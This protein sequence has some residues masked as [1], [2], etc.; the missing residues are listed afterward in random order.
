MAA[1]Q[2]PSVC[3]AGVSLVHVGAEA[4]AADGRILTGFSKEDFRVF[5]QGVAQQLV[6]F[7]AEEQPLALILLFD[8]S[9][10]M[11]S[12]G[13]SRW[14]ARRGLRELRPGDRVSVMVFN[15]RSRVVLPFSEDLDGV[16]RSIQQDVLG[17]IWRRHSNSSDRNRRWFGRSTRARPTRGIQPGIP[18]DF[19]TNSCVYFTADSDDPAKLI[20]LQG[21]KPADKRNVV[22]VQGAYS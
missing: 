11:R 18:A 19:G 17:A 5:D 20:L 6:H 2:P 9:G 22:G 12:G 13:A 14:A 15:A 1:A 3:R 4:I 7:S 10:S 21:N 8:I 16:E